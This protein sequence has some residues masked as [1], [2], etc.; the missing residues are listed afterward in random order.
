MTDNMNRC[1]VAG[2]HLYSTKNADF[3]RRSLRSKVPDQHILSNYLW[4]HPRPSIYNYLRPKRWL[5][6]GS[7]CANTWSLF[8]SVDFDLTVSSADVTATS[9]WATAN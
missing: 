4:S 3:E 8:V 5:S 7:P 6:G 2:Q 1:S 9:V